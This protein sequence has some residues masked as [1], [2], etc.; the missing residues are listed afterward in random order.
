MLC[1]QRYIR[2][3]MTLPSASCMVRMLWDDSGDVL[4]AQ[5]LIKV[6]RELGYEQT[7]GKTRAGNGWAL[8]RSDGNGE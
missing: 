3:D 5:S 8:K 6:L 1:V 2:K 7:T 4:S